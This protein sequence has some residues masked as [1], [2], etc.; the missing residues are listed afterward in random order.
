MENDEI[1]KMRDETTKAYNKIDVASAL[2]ELVPIQYYLT[3]I[4]RT[5]L[6]NNLL[7]CEIALRL[8]KK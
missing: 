5:G 6:T 2:I 7:L 1:V 3:D 4:L 8:E